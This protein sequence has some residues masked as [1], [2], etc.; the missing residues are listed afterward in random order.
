MK[1]PL[2]CLALLV[3]LVPAVASAQSPGRVDKMRAFLTRQATKNATDPDA[4]DRRKSRIAHMT[5]A[6]LERAWKQLGERDNRRAQTIEKRYRRA[7]DPAYRAA[8]VR[9]YQQRLHAARGRAGLQ[10][11][12]AW[13]PEGASLGVG[14]VVSPDRRYV[15]IT[16]APFFS[17]VGPVRTFNFGS[18]AFGHGHG[19]A[20]QPVIGWRPQGTTFSTMPAVQQYRFGR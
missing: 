6:E 15:R 1:T 20:Y 12:I 13:L 11:V 17:S 14:A 4:A 10:P 3:L 16:A 5:P 9:S 18:P 7:Q 8:A 2:F 19:L